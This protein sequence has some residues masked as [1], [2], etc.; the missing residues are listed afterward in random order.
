[1]NADGIAAHRR[2]GYSLATIPRARG[3]ADG[4]RVV[5]SAVGAPAGP[6]GSRPPD[7][8][9]AAAVPRRRGQLA[10]QLQEL[11]TAVVRL[12][13]RTTDV[14]A[15]A[16]AFRGLVRR[17]IANANQEAR[18]LGYGEEDVGYAV[19][20]VVAF[21][22]ETILALGHASFA[23]WQGRPLQ[24]EVF[25]ASVGGDVF[26]QYMERQFARDDSDDTADVLEVFLL[27][28]LLGFR[29]RYMGSEEG[30]HPWIA[31]ARERI[32]RIRGAP[33]PFAPNWAPTGG[34]PTSRPGDPWQ[35]RLLFALGGTLG[36]VL[37][38]WVIFWFVL[39]GES[40]RIAAG[41]VT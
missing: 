9:A 36:V 32:T 16:E 27:C 34:E 10:L 20:A 25:G 3:V 7:A 14:P 5:T 30:V 12:R 21:L 15:D 23:A 13:G 39:G 28:L 8:G 2:A 1:L 38:L 37:L 6:V 35:R 40:G 33:P 31:R 18:Q 11:L 29:G 24:E 26:Y 41:A 19:Y 17:L 4:I 22:D